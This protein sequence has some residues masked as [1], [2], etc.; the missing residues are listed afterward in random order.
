MNHYNNHL[1][2][3]TN[4]R[5]NNSQSCGD[6]GACSLLNYIKSECIRLN[7]KENKNLRIS[8]A[9]CLGNCKQGPVLVI[10]PEG[11]WYSYKNK[12]DIDNILQ[13]LAK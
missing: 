7:I 13:D 4:Q 6:S 11:K 10:Y 8:S 5:Q 2:I 1:F 12:E 3:C 9:G